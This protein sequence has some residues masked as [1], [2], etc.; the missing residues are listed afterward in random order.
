MEDNVVK[1]R[2]ILQRISWLRDAGRLDSDEGDD[3]ADAVEELMEVAEPAAQVRMRT[4]LSETGSK[5][6]Q[7]HTR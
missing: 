3:L 1:F 2:R 5:E 4:M 7:P 6:S